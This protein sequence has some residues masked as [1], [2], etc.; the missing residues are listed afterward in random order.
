ME[1]NYILSSIL[2]T[3]PQWQIG[4]GKEIDLNNANQLHPKLQILSRV[5]NNQMHRVNDL[6]I[7]DLGRWNIGLVKKQYHSGDSQ[8]ILNQCISNFG[9]SS[10]I[11]WPFCIVVIG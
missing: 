5:S 9:F 8:N 3:Q 1:G 10:T 7:P 6:I 11:I 2:L 4:S